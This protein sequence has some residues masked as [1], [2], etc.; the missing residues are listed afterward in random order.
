MIIHPSVHADTMTNMIV[1]SIYLIW[2]CSYEPIRS[3]LLIVS[4]IITNYVWWCTDQWYT[5]NTNIIVAVWLKKKVAIIWHINFH[6][7]VVVYA[8]TVV[9]QCIFK[10]MMNEIRVMHILLCQSQC[11]DS[12]MYS[13]AIWTL[14]VV[15]LFLNYLL[16][17]IRLPQK[18]MV[19]GSANDNEL[20]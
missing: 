19:L 20:S 11:T 7:L 4:D 6:I 12:V 5:T 15:V 13:A 10:R 2:T 3:R 8:P 1:T 9:E 16:E 14:P 17:F 18:R